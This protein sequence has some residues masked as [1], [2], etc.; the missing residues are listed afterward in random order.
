MMTDPIATLTGKE[1]ELI[2]HNERVLQ[3]RST[4]KTGPL[5][6]MLREEKNT[7]FF[8]LTILWKGSSYQGQV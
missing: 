3:Q 1:N 2:H 7:L 5:S 4:L 6:V 8:F